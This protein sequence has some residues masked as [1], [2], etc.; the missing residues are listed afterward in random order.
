M[1]QFLQSERI[2]LRYNIVSVL[3]ISVKKNKYILQDSLFQ[4]WNKVGSFYSFKEGK[5]SFY[6]EVNYGY[7]L[8]DIKFTINSEYEIFERTVFSFWEFIGQIGGI[9]E[10]LDLLFMFI[11]I[12]YNN[13]MFLLSLANQKIKILTDKNYTKSNS[14]GGLR[15]DEEEKLKNDEDHPNTLNH[16]CLTRT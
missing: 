14:N 3:D 8:S 10:I 6:D 11:V 7:H 5:H 15:I 13:K 2:A 12:P 9:Y 16:A 4:F 1:N